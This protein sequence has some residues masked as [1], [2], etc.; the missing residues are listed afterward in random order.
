LSSKQFKIETS[1]PVFY[2]TKIKVPS[3]YNIV[4]R[5]NSDKKKRNLKLDGLLYSQLMQEYYAN[6]PEKMPRNFP[7]SY[8]I[9]NGKST[10]LISIQAFYYPDKAKYF[11]F[12][13]SV[14]TDLQEKT[15]KKFNY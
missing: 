6:H 8:K 10:A 3:E 7:A 4:Y 5:I 15:D 11:S 14:Y 1:F 9:L 13:D 12:I 2:V